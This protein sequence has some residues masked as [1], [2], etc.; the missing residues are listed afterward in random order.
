MFFYS[1]TI[2]FPYTDII[3]PLQ[4]SLILGVIFVI[5]LFYA[6][7]PN[8]YWQ[9]EKFNSIYFVVQACW[10][11]RASLWRAFWPFFV[12]VNIVFFYIDYRIT[13]NTYT[14]ASWRTMHLILL[15][16]TVWWV[17]SVWKC[18]TNTKKRIWSTFARTISVYLVIDFFLRL[19]I[20]F[21]YAHL[22]LDCSLFD[23]DSGECLT[24]A[25]Y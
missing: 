7:Q 22:L 4:F 2:I 11:G 20:S 14:L 21:E 3:N 15:L 19:Y 12:V 25:R 10:L 6:P 1:L 8:I 18:S 17:R 16:P 24:Y 5:D 13:N 9:E 23:L